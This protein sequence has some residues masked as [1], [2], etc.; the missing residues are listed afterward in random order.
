MIAPD[1]RAQTIITPDQHQLRAGIWS[2]PGRAPS[3]AICVLLNGHTEFLE[4]YAEVAGELCARG[5]E[6]VSLD[7]RG[8][9]ASERRV[10][11]NRA[12]HIGNFEEYDIDLAAL[13]LQVVEPM[14]RSLPA[15]L[16]L[17][18]VAHSMGGHILLRY[19]HDHPRR[20]L[21]AVLCAPMVDIE[22]GKFSPAIAQLV[23]WLLNLRRPSKRPIFGIE[24]HDPL[25]LRFEDNVVTCD[26]GRFERNQ[27]ML[28]QQ[29]FLRISGPTFGWL[30]A[31]FQSIRRM[32]RRRFAGD[33]VTPLLVFGAGEDKVV[34]SEAIRALCQRLPNARYVEI[35]GAR[36]EILMETD[37]IR[38]GFWRDFDA[39]MDV[40]VPR[41]DGA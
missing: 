20:L 8:Q 27:D 4:K 11:G 32:R 24:R 30:G 35:K 9:G 12:G 16:P 28:R 1:F 5:F 18:A 3:R 21:C 34:R 2:M 19:L 40:H 23:A 41:R 33:V 15:P 38:A 6:V 31:A 37:A 36:H 7:W 14:Q 26:R 25:E 39:F 10:Y 22:T 29:P 13:I 17:V